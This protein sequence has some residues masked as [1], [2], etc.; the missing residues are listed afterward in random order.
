MNLSR[1]DSN[2]HVDLNDTTPRPKVVSPSVRLQ[3][4]LNHV[5][6]RESARSQSLE[7]KKV[8]I[9]KVKEESSPVNKL[10]RSLDIEDKS[11]SSK[12]IKQEN[13][14]AGQN[15]VNHN[16]NLMDENAYH[17]GLKYYFGREVVQDLDRAAFYFTRAGD[18]DAV[19]MLAVMAVKSHQGAIEGL[20]FLAD[21]PDQIALFNLGEM[22]YH[23]QGVG[24]NYKTAFNYL[25]IAADMG[26]KR[27]QNYVGLMYAGGF[28][29]KKDENLALDYFAL[30]KG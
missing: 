15:N 4:K 22:Y 25:K 6:K 27:A 13:A 19:D 11:L 12:R 24:Q 20:K 16:Y 18:H 9:V 28:G 10:K 23:G 1:I 8:K 7:E 5:P 14:I 30:A 21:R 17:L 29:V 26:H 2:N 3:K